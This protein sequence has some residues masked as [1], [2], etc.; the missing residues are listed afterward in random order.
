MS[1]MTD[2]HWSTD[3]EHA[4]NTVTMRDFVLNHSAGI[5]LKVMARD[6]AYGEFVDA[7]GNKYGGN[8]IGNGDC[9]NHILKLGLIDEFRLI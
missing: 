6:G 2:Y 5:G 9:F 3:D 4:D 7:D 1:T 8:A